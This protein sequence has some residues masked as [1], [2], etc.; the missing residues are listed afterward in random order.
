M[1]SNVYV[2]RPARGAI[3]LI[4]KRQ[5]RLHSLSVSYG[6]IYDNSSKYQAH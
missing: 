3:T 4:S 6:E 2:T 1:S 5:D